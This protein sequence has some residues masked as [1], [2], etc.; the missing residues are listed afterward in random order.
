MT[1]LTASGERALRIAI[2]I[3]CQDTVNAGFALDLARL[4]HRVGQ[5]GIITTIIQ[6]RGTILPQQRA[7]LVRAA[8]EFTATHILWLDSDMRFPADTLFRL[9]AHEEPIVA[10]NY[11]KRR[12]PILPTAEHRERGYLFTTPESEGLVEVTQCGM[13]IMLVDMTVFNTISQPWFAIGFNRQD[14]EYSGEDFFF[15]KKARESGFLTLIDQDLSKEVRHVGEMEFTAS[16]TV[17][18]RNAYTPEQVA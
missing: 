18:T 15:C 9:L 1:I 5:S 11:A 14:E 6:N 12:H 4:M 2:C 7:V 10:A 17:L 13:G 3:P 16:H 8:K